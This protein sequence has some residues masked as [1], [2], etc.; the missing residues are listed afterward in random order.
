M[1]RANLLRMAKYI[2]EVPQEKFNMFDFR[3][4]DKS[5]IECN[6]VG[7]VIGH[8]TVLE[9]LE[10]LEKFRTLGPKNI[11]FDFDSWSAVFTGLPS[12]EDKWGWC[13]GYSWVYS[14]NTP[15]GAAQRI[16]YLVNHGLPTNWERQMKGL[17]TLCY[18]DIKIEDYE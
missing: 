9:N 8:C 16:V 2:A 4:G 11:D 1:N 17:D 5:T 15:K 12:N 13:F 18:T 6:S 7:C 14:D 10:E 3:T